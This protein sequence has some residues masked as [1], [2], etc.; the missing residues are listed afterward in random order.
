MAVFGVGVQFI[1]LKNL[2][3]VLDVPF[4][5]KVYIY[6]RTILFGTSLAETWISQVSFLQFISFE[7][8][9]FFAY[10]HSIM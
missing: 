3:K 2:E 7:V 10:F 8:G 4:F 6:A 1:S 9:L 5:T